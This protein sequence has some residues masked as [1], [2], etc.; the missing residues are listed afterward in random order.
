[1]TS[2]EHSGYSAEQQHAMQEQGA[3]D[4][5]SPDNEHEGVN[6]RGEKHGYRQSDDDVE[7][8]HDL[9]DLAD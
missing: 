8:D 4:P 3:F 1:M 6:V 5:P 2:W 7:P 9:W